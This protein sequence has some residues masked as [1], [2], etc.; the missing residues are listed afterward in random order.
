V[1]DESEPYSAA[2]R[3][4][5]M[6]SG[7]S[8][9]VAQVGARSIILREPRSFEPQPADLIITISGVPQTLPIILMRPDPGQ[10]P[11]EIRYF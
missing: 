8:I 11:L 4:T 9:D 10:S 1:V 3:L 7:E 6:V 5:L 2:V